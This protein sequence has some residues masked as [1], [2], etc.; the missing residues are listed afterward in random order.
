MKQDYTFK[1][2]L[3][4]GIPIA[5]GY[6]SVS[7]GFGITAVNKGLSV[8]E[9]LLISMTNLTSA[10]QVAGLSVIVASGTIIEMI[11]VQFIINLRYALMSVSL[12]QKLNSSFGTLHRFLASAGI[13][14]EIFAV[15]SSKE[16]EISPKYMYG[17]IT[18][19]YIGWALG[20]FIGAAAGAVLPESVKMALGIAIYA[21]FVAIIVPPMRR[22]WGV[23]FCVA[24]AAALSCVFRYVPIIN[25]VT[26]GFAVIICS[27][28]ASVLAALIFPKKVEEGGNA[29]ES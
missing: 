8:I 21:M 19:P 4:D 26:F 14:D 16:H 28:V 25:K 5:L 2:G 20:T 1:Q 24:V 15:A 23:A 9:A 7:F 29:D 10:G 17:L 13:T 3:K 18:I 27:V 6:L 22:S 11:M 12:S